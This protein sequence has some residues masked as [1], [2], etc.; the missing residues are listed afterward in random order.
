MAAQ[1]ASDKAKSWHCGKKDKVKCEAGRLSC[2]D[3]RAVEAPDLTGCLPLAAHVEWRLPSDMLVGEFASLLRDHLGALLRRRSLTCV[4]AG[5]S[6]PIEWGAQVVWLFVARV[7]GRHQGALVEA[8]LSPQTC[9]AL[10]PPAMPQ[11]DQG[12]A[13][14]AA[15]STPR[16]PP[17]PPPLH[18]K[19]TL[20][21]SEM[22]SDYLEQAASD[23]TPCAVAG[24]CLLASALHRARFPAK[25]FV[26]SALCSRAQSMTM[27]PSGRRYALLVARWVLTA[28]VCGGRAPFARR[29]CRRRPG[30]HTAQRIRVAAR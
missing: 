8:A 22:M 13:K 17:P 7:V 26:P 11:L 2:A 20:L 21:A 30:I 1:V 19:A 12:K 25:A 16:A 6:L 10:V 24:V 28:E 18:D 3:C 23:G 4:K 5:T 29:V 27:A 14:A 9:H 15:A